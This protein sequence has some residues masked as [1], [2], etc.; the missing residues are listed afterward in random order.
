MITGM[1]WGPND[2]M[3]KIEGIEG[4]GGVIQGREEVGTCGGREME[5]GSM[6]KP[7]GSQGRKKWGERRRLIDAHPVDGLGPERVSSRF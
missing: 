5:R 7:K 2:G 3:K 1:R 6:K 4:E